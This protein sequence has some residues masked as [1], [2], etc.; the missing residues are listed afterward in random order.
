MT[1]DVHGNAVRSLT[2]KTRDG[3][4]R[5]VI[6]EIGRRLTGDRN[7]HLLSKVRRVGCVLLDV[8]GSKRRVGAYLNALF[9]C[10][11]NEVIAFV[12]GSSR[13]LGIFAVFDRL[14]ILAD[15]ATVV[16]LIANS[17]FLLGELDSNGCAAGGVIQRPA[18]TTSIQ[19]ELRN[20]AAVDLANCIVDL[21]G[22]NLNV[23]AFRHVDIE[24]NICAVQVV[25]GI[26]N[27]EI[28]VI[29]ERRLEIGS[30][31]AGFVFRCLHDAISRDVL[32]VLLDL[33]GDR[34][35]WEDDLLPLGEELVFAIGQRVFVAGIVIFTRA[36][37]LGVPAGEL[38]SVAREPVF[39]DRN[40][41]F[42]LADG[43]RH[44]T[45]AT[46]CVVE[47]TVSVLLIVDIDDVFAILL[48]R[49]G[50]IGLAVVIGVVLEGAHHI[51]RID[52][53]SHRAHRGIRTHDFLSVHINMFDRQIC[54]VFCVNLAV[55]MPRWTLCN[56]VVCAGLHMKLCPRCVVNNER[57][58]RPVADDALHG[59]IKSLS[60]TLVIQIDS[61]I[62]VYTRVGH[63][64]ARHVY[65][66]NGVPA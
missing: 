59:L 32:A 50:V 35:T 21:V 34:R 7:F 30:A 46:I 28:A 36:V 33:N 25:V 31:A 2:H 22:Y 27:V 42:G 55:E 10:P 37:G 63:Q 11:V 66:A 23:I 52:T 12:R 14:G 17:E 8:L 47:Q 54:K 13:A 60:N 61:L 65:N 18:I 45:F 43:R 41:L 48:D 1:V 26:G 6:D 49:D 3:L 20:L 57:L 24:R 4:L 9:V 51:A 58:V 29:I 19:L 64:I 62:L 40:L 56:I 38:V 53:R 15:P 16:G 5:P 44:G 39:L